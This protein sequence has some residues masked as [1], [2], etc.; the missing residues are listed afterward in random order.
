MTISILTARFRRST[1]GR[2]ASNATISTTDMGD[3]NLIDCLPLE[4]GGVRTR[5]WVGQVRHLRLHFS[6]HSLPTR[7]KHYVG[8]NRSD[9][10][11]MIEVISVRIKD[12]KSRLHYRF[13]GLACIVD[14]KFGRIPAKPY[15]NVFEIKAMNPTVPII[16]GKCIQTFDRGP[17]LPNLPS[18]M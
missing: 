7:L 13:R 10:I 15:P 4:Y 12:L 17:I 3:D 8:V 14:G 11:C 6:M 16:S 1:R 18:M 9:R 2:S 5:P